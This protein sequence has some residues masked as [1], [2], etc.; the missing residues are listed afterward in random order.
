MDSIVRY[1][2]TVFPEFRR[3]VLMSGSGV[4]LFENLRAPGPLTGA[5]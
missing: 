3:L 1:N 5:R 4:L 2:A